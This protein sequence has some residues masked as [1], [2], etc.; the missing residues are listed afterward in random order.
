MKKMKRGMRSWLIKILTGQA[1]KT[2]KGMNG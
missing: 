1:Q 2:G